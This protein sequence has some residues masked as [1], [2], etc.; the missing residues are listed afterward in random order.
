MPIDLSRYPKN[1]HVISYYIRHVRAGNRCENASCK[2]RN[3][4]PHPITGSRVVLT[5]AHTD[6]SKSDDEFVLRALCQRCHFAL[7]RP[8][9]IARRKHRDNPQFEFFEP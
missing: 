2:A 4:E 1:W 7:D 3:G 5:V 9:H 6:Q 8:H